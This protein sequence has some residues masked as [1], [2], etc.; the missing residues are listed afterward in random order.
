MEKPLTAESAKNAEEKLLERLFSALSA[1]SAV[2][3]LLFSA[4]FLA[5]WRFILFLP[6]PRRSGLPAFP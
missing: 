4:F 6:P 1:P 5:F 3:V 2:Q